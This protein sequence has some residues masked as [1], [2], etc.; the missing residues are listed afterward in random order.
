MSLQTA[1]VK[2]NRPIERRGLNK[3]AISPRLCL[4]KS[5]AAHAPLSLG[6][7]PSSARRE[8]RS[9]VA[10]GRLLPV[11]AVGIPR[12]V[13]GEEESR[14]KNDGEM[15]LSG[16]D[17]RADRARH[18]LFLGM[19]CTSRHAII[20]F[21]RYI[22]D[23]G[24]RMHHSCLNC[25]H[26]P[27]SRYAQIVN[28]ITPSS[29]GFAFAH[30]GLTTCGIFLCKRPFVWRLVNGLC[31]GLPFVCPTSVVSVERDPRTVETFFANSTRWYG[32]WNGR[33]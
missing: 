12:S 17:Y 1:Y 33:R 14:K 20:R 9:H 7:L 15:R 21:S 8:F 13:C 22:A 6:S 28:A 5:G 31:R 25:K 11:L 10:A 3:C 2:H 23:L 19:R 24:L 27:Q 18:V 4:I 26:A 30:F 16:S 32:S 29:Y